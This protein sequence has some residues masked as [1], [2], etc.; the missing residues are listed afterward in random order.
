MKLRKVPSTN[1]GAS[2]ARAKRQSAAI[3]APEAPTIPVSVS[4]FP[5]G[6]VRAGA[7]A[8][9][10]GSSCCISTHMTAPACSITARINAATTVHLLGGLCT[11]ADGTMR[12]PCDRF[13]AGD[14]NIRT[15]RPFGATSELFNVVVCILVFGREG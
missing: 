9:D 6:W 2:T 1:S 15:T 7:T 13:L 5:M 12:R 10:G 3:L 11:A 8:S 4:K 14:R